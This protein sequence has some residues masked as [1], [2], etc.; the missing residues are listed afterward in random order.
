MSYDQAIRL[1]GSDKP[2]MR[3]PAMTAVRAAFTEE[4]LA[5]LAVNPSLPVVCDPHTEGWRAFP[6]RS[7]RNQAAVQRAGCSE[8]IRRF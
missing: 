2:D 1:Y 6:K 8:V 4:N 7:R 3:V 5:T